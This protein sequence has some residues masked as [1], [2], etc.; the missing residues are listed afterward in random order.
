MNIKNA[1]KALIKADYGGS[2]EG[3][4]ECDFDRPY[5]VTR[6]EMRFGGGPV[7]LP[8]SG[9]LRIVG[10]MKEL[11]VDIWRNLFEQMSA[12]LS[13]TQVA[14][15]NKP[16]KSD[17]LPMHLAI[18][19]SVELLVD[20][21]V[22]LGQPAT[23]LK[24]SVS[25]KE[26]WLNI[27]LDSKE[28][29]GVVTVPKDLEQERLIIDMKHLHLKTPETSG[30][31]IDPRDL[32]AIN[33]NSR[34]VAYDNKKL[35]SVAIETSK[36]EKGML[37]QQLIMNPRETT[38]KGHGHWLIEKGV[39]QSLLDF[40]LES[41]DLGKTMKD[42][43]YVETIEEGEGKITAKLRWPSTIFDPDFSHLS[44]EVALDF[45]NGRILDIEPGRAARLFG[46]FSIQTLP[47][48]LTLDFSD[49][50]AKGLSFDFV[51]GNFQLENGDAYTNNFKLLGTNAD[52]A[53]K[54][55]IG[56]AAQDYDQKV[57]VTPHITDAAV[58]LS[59]LTAQPLI[60]LFQQILKADIEGAA[61][62]EYALTGPWNNSTLTPILQQPLFDDEVDEF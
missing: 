21:F 7:V 48:R 14:V 36:T 37:L 25:K 43:G 17:R 61:S 58:L 9:G 30:G 42:L 41:K 40:E 55:R 24:L 18:V 60:I 4:F 27:N 2:F 62:I 3:I 33:F 57:R 12:Q 47:R 10:H 29:L 13:S 28:M 8:R 50:F 26:D 22:Y 44:G 39:H 19:N 56:L 32:P 46:L 51:T 11:S 31:E 54:G 59:I 52:I 49:M 34:F 5:W 1:D 45:K 16:E 23:N 6:G 35:G 20:K 38:I 15:D 53:L